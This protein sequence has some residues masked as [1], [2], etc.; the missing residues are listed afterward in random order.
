M[1]LEDLTNNELEDAFAFSKLTGFNGDVI[2]EHIGKIDFSD[3]SAIT[4]ED[5]SILY[6]KDLSYNYIKMKSILDLDK[7]KCEIK[8]KNYVETNIS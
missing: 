5:Y 6:L 2:S 4:E 7:Q 3:I 1:K 8:N